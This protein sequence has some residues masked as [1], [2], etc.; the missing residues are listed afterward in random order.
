VTKYRSFPRRQLRRLF[1]AWARDDWKRLAGVAAGAASLITFE[2]AVLVASTI[3]VAV[4]WYVIGALH[5]AIVAVFLGAIATTFLAH[6]REA[7]WYLRGAWGEDFTKDEL[8]RA[9]RKKLIWGWV[10]SVTVE[11]GDIDHLVVTK[12][13]GVVAIDTKYRS[14][15]QDL[16]PARMAA[17]AGK[18]KLRA[19]GVI[20]T[21]LRKERGSHRAAIKAFTVSPL[22]VVWGAATVG[23]PEGARINDVDVVSGAGLVGW[24]ERLDGEAIDEAAAA[25]LLARL[26]NFRTTAWKS[27]AQG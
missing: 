14:S 8:A 9:R 13:G 17:E 18:A 2:T 11:N 5:V 26:E 23:V 15:S 3:D 7:I 20:Q 27:K 10:D 24:L 1:W 6:Q 12:S 16:D 22:V 4:R 25:D 19:E 21:F